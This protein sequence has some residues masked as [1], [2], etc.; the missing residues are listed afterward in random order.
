MIY[1]R[2]IGRAQ[3]P[4]EERQRAT[5][6]FNL[7]VDRPA[8]SFQC[9]S[10]NETMAH[11]QGCRFGGATGANDAEPHTQTFLTRTTVIRFSTVLPQKFIDSVVQDR[12]TETAVYGAECCSY[13]SLAEATVNSCSDVVR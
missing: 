6:I 13:I 10:D 4:S 7:S 2:Q 8:V 1:A 9:L 3:R 11:C 12:I 5:S